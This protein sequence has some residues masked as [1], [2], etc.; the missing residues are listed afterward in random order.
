MFVLLLLLVVDE[1]QKRLPSSR[2]GL[3]AFGWSNR[4]R[5]SGSD[6]VLISVN[7]SWCW[8][9]EAAP[10]AKSRLRS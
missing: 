8:T 4:W 10:I 7:R 2:P 1:E 3:S 5:S 9:R 6:A